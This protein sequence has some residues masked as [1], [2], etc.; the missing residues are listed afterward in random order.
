MFEWITG[1]LWLVTVVAVAELAR[2]LYLNFK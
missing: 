2:I 1:H